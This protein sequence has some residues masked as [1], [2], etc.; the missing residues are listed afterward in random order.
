VTFY[1]LNMD[2]RGRI[3]GCDV[4]A[5]TRG[6]LPFQVDHVPCLS[7]TI[8][9]VKRLDRDGAASLG[10]TMLV[11]LNQGDIITFGGALDLASF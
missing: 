5:M 8:R 7:A 6:A 4:V 9:G 1:G 2:E 10:E 3:T 11:L